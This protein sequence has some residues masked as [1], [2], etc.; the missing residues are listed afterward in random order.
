MDIQLDVPACTAR[1]FR[2]F[3]PEII[4]GW[5]C[6]A[7]AGRTARRLGARRVL[8]VTQPGTV[9]VGWI[10][11]L[12]QYLEQ[13]GLEHVTWDGISSDPRD[14]EV[15]AAL[16]AYRI[17]DCDVLVGMGGRAAM[18][19]AKA[20][21]VL[22]A[23]GGSLADYDGFDRVTQPTPPT[24]MIPTIV[25]SGAGVLQ[26]CTISDTSHRR[27]V[28]MLG[29]ALV[30]DV[31]LVDPAILGAQPSPLV[32]AGGFDALT[33]AIEGYLGQATTAMTEP[34]ALAAVRLIGDHLVQAVDAPGDPDDATALATAGVHAGVAATNSVR[35]AVDALAGLLADLVD[36]PRGIVKGVLLPHVIRCG[37]TW[38]AKRYRAVADALRLDTAGV[39]DE[40]VARA[41]AGHVR[42]TADKV[43]IPAGLWEL[44]IGPE[45][46]EPVAR[47][48][49]QE[50][51][52]NGADP[53][54]ASFET[55]SAILRAALQR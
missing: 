23:N 50:I 51:A 19:A 20:V 12:H 17:R 31:S 33:M 46:V 13:A 55:V 21:A 16:Q 48:A 35:S 1:V 10:A 27:M 41:V 52:A 4:L 39:P 25:G 44:G 30:A 11:E 24:V 45:T 15:V 14:V 38:L 47:R 28:R 36:L 34:H 9:E 40:W 2:F 37:P 22:S 43:G 6:L 53:R 32:A 5:G 54:T 3:L 42:A 26:S 49:T 18:D 7:E 8:L 29:C